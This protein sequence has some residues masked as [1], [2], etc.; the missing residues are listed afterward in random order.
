MRTWLLAVALFA[1]ALSADPLGC[2]LADYKPA[3]GLTAQ[4]ADN[5]LVIIWDGDRGR[6]VRLRL[7]VQ[8][9][10]PTIRDLSIRP[11]GTAWIELAAHAVPEFRIVSGKRR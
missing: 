11:K 7:A 6:E 10:V 2:N 4:V 1:P 9:G 8:S 5:T 3:P